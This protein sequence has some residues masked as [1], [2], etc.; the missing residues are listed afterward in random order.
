PGP[1]ASTRLAEAVAAARE[2]ETS[3]LIHIHSDPLVYAPDGEGWWDV[4][5]AE[6]STMGDTQA[7]RH[8][9]EIA[10]KKQRPLL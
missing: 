7:A 5:V 2:A 3:T 8:E 6:V 4:P 10:V 1:D 9:Y